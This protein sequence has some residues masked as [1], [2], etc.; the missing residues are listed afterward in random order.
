MFK[1]APSYILI[2]KFVNV[3]GGHQI[4]ISGCST[5]IGGTSYLEDAFC[6]HKIHGIGIRCKW[7]VSCVFCSYHLMI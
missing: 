1:L 5:H 3:F 4:S 7:L 2:E 6:T